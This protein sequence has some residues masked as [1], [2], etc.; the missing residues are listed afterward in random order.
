MQIIA[1][2]TRVAC[3]CSRELGMLGT[4]RL[5]V[6]VLVLSLGVGSYGMVTPVMTSIR[7]SRAPVTLEQ[8]LAKLCVKMDSAHTFS[9]GGASVKDVESH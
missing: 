2:D 4:M 1:L 6:P 7:A 9:R 5:N 8:N 3:A